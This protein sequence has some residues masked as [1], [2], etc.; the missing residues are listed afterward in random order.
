MSASFLERIKNGEALVSDGAT[1]TNLQQRGL[2]AGKPGEV[3]VLERSDEILQLHRD[4]V[5]AGSDVILTCTFGGTSIRLAGEGLDERTVELNQRAV[6]LAR[7]AVKD[8]DVL[9]AGSIGPTG[10]MLKPLGTL[11]EED[12]YQ[13]FEEQARTLAKAGVDLLVVETMYDLAEAS[14]AVKAVKTVCDLPLVCSFSYD[15]G[16]RTMMGVKPAQMAKQFAG[17]ADLLGI[18][19]GKSLEDNLEALKE[20]RTATDL[21]IWFK[22][23]AGLPQV[24]AEGRTIFDI[25]AD[26]MGAKVPDWLAAGA[27]VV[28]GCCGSSPAH[29][30]A[31][32][33]AAKK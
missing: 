24:D 14:L 23:N 26:G 2:A 25:T 11:E 32:A 28:G 6:A 7:E 18:N 10:Q 1:G 8:T 16:T 3:W 9:V 20:L 15:R 21:P 17:D 5:A 4:F 33:S 30:A 29:V 12:C 27:S 13:S 22:P 19:C 31:I